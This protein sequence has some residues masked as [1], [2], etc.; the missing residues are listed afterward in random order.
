MFPDS[1]ESQQKE[2]KPVS[3]M[4]EATQVQ[5]MKPVWPTCMSYNDLSK[6]AADTFT[7]ILG[8]IQLRWRRKQLQKRAL[9]HSFHSSSPS[10]PGLL[11]VCSREILPVQFSSRIPLKAKQTTK[12]LD[13]AL[14]AQWDIYISKEKSRLDFLFGRT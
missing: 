10:I 4:W 6:V 5:S 12:G 2:E 3:H 9:Q 11:S 8:C 14:D 7:S 13:L 1:T